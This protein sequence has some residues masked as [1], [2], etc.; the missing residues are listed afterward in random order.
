MNIDNQVWYVRYFFYTCRAMDEFFPRSFKRNIRYQNGADLCTMMRT[1]LL[2]TIASLLSMVAW[3]SPILVLLVLPVSLFGLGSVA[4]FV[5]M[6]VLGLAALF[7]L[8]WAVDCGVPRAIKWGVNRLDQACSI[9][10]SRPGF[11]SVLVQWALAIKNKVC[12]VIRFDNVNNSNN[13]D[14]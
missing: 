13:E 9:D 7:A 5:A 1:M 6:L 14:K 8:F 12:P 10:H 2:G 11:F 3:A 4:M